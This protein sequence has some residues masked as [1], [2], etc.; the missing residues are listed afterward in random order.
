MTALRDVEESWPVQSSE[1]VFQGSL[2]G[3]RRDTLAPTA[4]AEEPFD[5]EVVTHPGAVAVV[6]VDSEGRMLVIQQYRHAARKRMVEIP[7]GLLDVEG[8]PPLEAARRELREEGLLEAASWTPLVT[9]QPS[10][11]SSE[12]VVSIYLA[13]DLTEVSVP[14]GFGAVHEEASLTRDWVDVDEVVAAVLAGEVR[15][16]LTIAGS[17]ALYARRRANHQ[18]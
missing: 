12:E 11:G 17:L 7:A 4:A 8:E 2:L 13:E 14:V 10:A 9:F 18:F 1:T 5:R 15:N 16:G 3:V 6:A